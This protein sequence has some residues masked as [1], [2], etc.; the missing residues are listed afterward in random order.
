VSSVSELTDAELYDK[1]PRS[2][3]EALSPSNRLREYWAGAIKVHYDKLFKKGVFVVVDR[4]DVPPDALKLRSMFI[5]VV[6]P[7]KFSA[8]G[9]TGQ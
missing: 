8:L 2:V 7:D 5:F 9:G 1:P 3:K 4:A 6:K